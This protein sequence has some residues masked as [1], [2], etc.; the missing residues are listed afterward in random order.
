[1]INKDRWQPINRLNSYYKDLRSSEPPTDE[2]LTGLPSAE[3]FCTELEERKIPI[4]QRSTAALLR[5]RQSFIRYAIYGAIG[6]AL[7]SST[8]RYVKTVDEQRSTRMDNYSLKNDQEPKHH[9]GSSLE[10]LLQKSNDEIARLTV[11]NRLQR[12]EIQALR[13]I[14]TQH[15]IVENLEEG[16]LVPAPEAEMTSAH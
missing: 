16:T 12:S 2:Y 7:A 11:E 15:G 10:N 13:Q 4:E 1:M 14:F 5:R 9:V 6:M 8:G 3:K